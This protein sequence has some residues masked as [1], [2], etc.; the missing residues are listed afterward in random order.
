MS[1][2]TKKWLKAA[3]IR[4]TK[5]MAQIAL[6]MLTVGQ[7]VFEINWLN[8]ASVSITAGIMSLLTSL[9]GIPEVGKGGKIK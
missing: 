3:S 2:K 5:T 4:A 1:E 6:S 7:A 9:A 8:V